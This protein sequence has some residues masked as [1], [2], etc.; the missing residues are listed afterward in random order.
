MRSINHITL[1]FALLACLNS[2]FAQKKM[3]LT[4][5]AENLKGIFIESDQIFQIYV[6]TTN[7]DQLVISTEVEGETFET[8]E[9][10]T[11]LQNDLLYITTGRSV[12]FKAFDDKL[13]AHKV[14][15]V[16]L[17]IELPSNKELWVNSSLASVEAQGAYS[18]VNLNL[19]GGRVDLLNFSGN[20]VVNTLRGAIAIETQNTAV[21][22]S[23]RN[24]TVDVASSPLQLYELVLKTVDGDISVSQSE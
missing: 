3:V 5:P 4:E 24:G 6:K 10:D 16:V 17:H 20:G 2:A 1:F 12:G 19:S 18:Y 15:S 7:S 9:I 23:S 14:L 8:L 22:A 21:K 13:A 11:A